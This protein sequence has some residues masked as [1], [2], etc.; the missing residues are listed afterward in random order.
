MVFRVTNFI[1][2]YRLLIVG[3]EEPT[4]GLGLSYKTG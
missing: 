3:K 1:F 4:E 2:D